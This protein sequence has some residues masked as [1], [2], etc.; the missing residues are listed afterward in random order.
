MLRF[1]RQSTKSVLRKLCLTVACLACFHSVASAQTFEL[2]L[3]QAR[4]AARQAALS[5]QFDVARDF[6][7]A[8]LDADEND[9]A[10]LVVLAAV[11]P[12]LGDA[13]EGRRAGARAFRLSESDT[14]RYEAARLTALAAAN[15]E[16]YTL[17]QIWLR[18]AAINAPNDAALQQTRQDYRGIRNLNPLSVNLAFSL[19]PSNNANGGSDEEFNVVDGIPFFGVIL[20]ES[21]AL[22]GTVGTADLRLTYGISRTQE[23]R[24]S[25]TARAYARAVWLND[26]GRTIS[27]NSRNSDFG[28]QVFELSVDHDRRLGEGLLSAHALVGALWYGGELS[29]EY[30]RGRLSYARPI[31]ART[32]LSFTGVLDEIY[33]NTSTPRTNN[34]STIASAL[35]YVTD[36]GN[37]LRGSLA[38]SAQS[39]PQP[40]ERYETLT[41]Q[42]S[43]AW[44]DP[45]GPVQLSVSGGIT[46]ADYRDYIALVAVPD[47]RQDT[48][49]FAS[50]SAVLTNIDYAGFVPVLTLSAQDTQSNVSLF[51]RSEY[52]LSLGVRSSF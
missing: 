38:F 30:A 40:N 15:E 9:R 50:V 6:A 19:A 28:V 29:N 4:V 39:S 26:E 31:S 5:G 51:D 8:L 33:R 25:V 43:Y 2:S 22:P 48:R 35:S 47:G 7:L 34:A 24:T 20:P 37:T 52:S 12:Q 27:P 23:Q 17:S 32:Q 46:Q 18:R 3:D 21:R 10:A 16:R 11:H 44:A 1:A 13:R 49:T 14:E 42:V 36:G 45:F 41:A